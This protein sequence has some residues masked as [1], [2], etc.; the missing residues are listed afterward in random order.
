MGFWVVR[1]LLPIAPR[2]NCLERFHALGIRMKAKAIVLESSTGITLHGFLD[3]LL[4]K[5]KQW[6]GGRYDVALKGHTMDMPNHNIH[7]VGGMVP[8]THSAW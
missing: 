6:S 7:Y 8:N 3:R 5:F 2:H 4:D 1:V